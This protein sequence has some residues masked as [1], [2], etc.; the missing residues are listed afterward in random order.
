LLK[1]A[2][3]MFLFLLQTCHDLEAD[4]GKW[5][6]EEQHITIEYTIEHKI[7]KIVNAPKLWLIWFTSFQD[8]SRRKKFLLLYMKGNF[9]HKIFKRKRSNIFIHAW[10]N[11][12]LTML[13]CLTWDFR[14]FALDSANKK[15]VFEMD[16]NIWNW[17]L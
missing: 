13:M 8:S 11:A 2:V 7:L 10:L 12:M 15:L 17:K 9:N 5:V 3:F 14:S 4:S 1:V 16:L 6:F